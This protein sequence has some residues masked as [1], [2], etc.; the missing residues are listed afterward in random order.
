MTRMLTPVETFPG[1]KPTLIPDL[2]ALTTMLEGLVRRAGVE[3]HL[4]TAEQV[5]QVLLQPHDGVQPD[6]LRD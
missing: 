5:R 1:L 4:S 2:D 3:P 6:L